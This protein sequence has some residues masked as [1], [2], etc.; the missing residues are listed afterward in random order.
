MQ[1]SQ[2]AGVDE[3][4]AREY[5]KQAVADLVA[6]KPEVLREV[7]EEI[8]ED[9]ALIRAIEEG[10]TTRLVSMEQ[11]MRTLDEVEARLQDEAAGG[12]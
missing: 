4:Q 5:L 12:A 10:R 6:R 11:V 1:A 3:A 8:L 2:A 7:V 9:R